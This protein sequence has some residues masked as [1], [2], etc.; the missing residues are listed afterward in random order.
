[1]SIKLP[2]LWAKK[3]AIRVSDVG[4]GFYIVNFETIADYERAMFGGP[5]MVAIL[6]LIGDRI[7]KTVRIDHTTLEGSRGNFARICVEVDLSKPLLSKY[8]LRRRVRRIEYEGL[9]TICFNCGCF[10]HKV[11][12][13]KQAPEVE[14]TENQTTSFVN[15]VFQAAPDHEV[16]PEIEEDFG[17]WMQVKRNKRRQKPTESPAA[18]A[19]VAGHKV[20]EAGKG[21]SFAVIADMEGGDAEELIPPSS[22]PRPLGF[23]VNEPLIE[24]LQDGEKEN[25]DPLVGA[26]PD[27][28][29]L[30]A[31]SSLGQSVGSARSAPGLPGFFNSTQADPGLGNSKQAGPLLCN[32]VPVGTVHARPGP[33]GQG[34]LH[35]SD[36]GIVSTP[37]TVLPSAAI[38]IVSHKKNGA[39]SKPGKS[40]KNKSRGGVSTEGLKLKGSQPLG[41]ASDGVSAME[42]Q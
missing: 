37:V 24:D 22:M 27:S 38:P 14:V 36:A 7:G 39:A 30:A 13:C 18:V 26:P 25:F 29:S 2:Q 15:P 20:D 23:D 35:K 19:T 5:W 8:R 11:E 10:G 4:F 9:H 40:I 34:P 41:G 28:Q 42:V 3:G 1:M 32:E 16:R 21:N 31:A 33:A 6:K 17:P 12:A